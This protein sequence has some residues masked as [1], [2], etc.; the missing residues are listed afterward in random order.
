[1][2]II[3]IRNVHTYPLSIEYDALRKMLIVGTHKDVRLINILNGQTETVIKTMIG[4]NDDE[5]TV[6]KPIQ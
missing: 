1:M 3:N 2:S 5:M 4:E 6:F